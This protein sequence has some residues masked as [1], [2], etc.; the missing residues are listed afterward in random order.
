MAI[1]LPNF[2]YGAGAIS[3][4]AA[5]QTDSGKAM[6]GGLAALGLG[7]AVEGV[8]AVIE[9]RSRP[10]NTPIALDPEL[11]SDFDAMV[12]KHGKPFAERNGISKFSLGLFF[13]LCFSHLLNHAI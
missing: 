10:R 1:S 4:F 5:T 3:I 13:L 9:H 6:V 8:S 12:E 7:A 11:Q 2:L